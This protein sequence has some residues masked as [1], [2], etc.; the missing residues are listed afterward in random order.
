MGARGRQLKVKLESIGKLTPGTP[1]V[2]KEIGLAR[3]EKIIEHDWTP[4]NDY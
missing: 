2:A 3:Y 1:I 4:G